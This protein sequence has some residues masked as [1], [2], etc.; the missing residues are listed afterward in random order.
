MRMREEALRAA[1]REHYIACWR[2]NEEDMTLYRAAL[3]EEDKDIIQADAR[4]QAKKE[5]HSKALSDWQEDVQRFRRE[6]EARH[7]EGKSPTKEE[8][9]ELFGPPPALEEAPWPGTRNFLVYPPALG[10]AP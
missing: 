10:E 1:V 9:E 5:D 8:T 4:F 7:S 6:Y 2:K 3:T